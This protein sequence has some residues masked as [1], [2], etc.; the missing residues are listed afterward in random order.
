M[1][2]KTTK[3]G[4]SR[5]MMDTSIEER[6]KS[7]RAQRTSEYVIFT[8]RRR[9]VLK[10][11]EEGIVTILEGAEVR[12][13]FYGRG[14]RILRGDTSEGAKGPRGLAP[15]LIPTPEVRKIL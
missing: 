1:H 11:L 15:R 14:G 12:V 9:W 4:G 10:P 13:G 8:V 2:E 5:R 7:G 6:A 3:E